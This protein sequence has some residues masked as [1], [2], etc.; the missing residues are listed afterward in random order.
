MQDPGSLPRALPPA[1]RSRSRRAG[2]GGAAGGAVPGSGSGSGAAPAPIGSAAAR[3][4]R[5]SIKAAPVRPPVRLSARRRPAMPPPALPWL[6]AA[7]CLCALPRGSGT[8][9][10]L[11]VWCGVGGE[12]DTSESPKLCKGS[13]PIE[14][15]RRG[16]APRQLRTAVSPFSPPCP[17]R[18]PSA[19]L[20]LQGRRGPAQKPGTSVFAFVWPSS[21][22]PPAR[23]MRWRCRG[24]PVQ[25]GLAEGFEK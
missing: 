25:P 20:A 10:P 18:V 1:G 12:R 14:G 8:S 17:R 22:S 13:S 24:E 21:P 4:R 7:C 6:L 3:A 2:P 15:R 9:R 19:L 5:G 11:C 23:P 16:W